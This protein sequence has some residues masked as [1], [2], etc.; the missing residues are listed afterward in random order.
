MQWETT[1]IM[2][3]R[4]RESEDFAWTQFTDRFRLPLIRFAQNCGLSSTEAEDATQDAMMKFVEA[5]RAGRYDRSRGR[6]GSWLFTIAYQ[7]IRSHRRDAGRSP[8]QAPVVSGRTTFFSAIPDEQSARTQWDTDWDRYLLDA[9]LHQLRSELNPTHLLAFELVAIK[10]VPAQT[11][12]DELGISRD[13][14]YQIRYR[15][16]KRLSELRE[17]L[18]AVEIGTG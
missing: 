1:T 7:S 13:T 15:A 18:D 16:L 14:V 4:L 8:V 10:E 11:V 12:A 6:L 9:C 17:T 5:Y 3:E 2:L